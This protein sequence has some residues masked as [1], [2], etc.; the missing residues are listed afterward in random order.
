MSLLDYSVYA[1]EVAKN[2]KGESSKDVIKNLKEK[3]EKCMIS[4]WTKSYNEAH[5]HVVE[6]MTKSQIIQEARSK[7][8]DVNEGNFEQV[9]KRYRPSVGL[10]GNACQSRTCPWFLK[11]M[12]TYNQHAYAERANADFPH[13]LHVTSKH[14][15]TENVDTI[16]NKII[17]GEYR[18]SVKGT[19]EERLADLDLVPLMNAYKQIPTQ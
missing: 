9:Y 16:T 12:K 1:A 11:P 14:H 8:V 2:V 3:L 5:A 17:A 18:R 6:P 13:G 4:S 15:C 10:M 19:T 7:G